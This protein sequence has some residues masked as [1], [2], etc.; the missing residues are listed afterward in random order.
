MGFAGIADA[1][2]RAAIIAYLR[3]LSPAPLPLFVEA[4]GIG[5]EQAGLDAVAF[6]AAQVDLGTASYRDGGCTECHGAELR[7]EV[8]LREDGFGI[9]PPLVGPNFVQ[10]WFRGTVQELFAYLQSR[11][12]PGNPGSMAPEIYADIIAYI[13]ARNGFAP[14]DMA[15]VPDPAVLG[16]TGFYQ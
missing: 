6:T 11:K 15:L 9:A 16:R 1:G 7:G 10:R 2:D 13:L 3:T 8:D 12:P 14:G 4:G 5:N